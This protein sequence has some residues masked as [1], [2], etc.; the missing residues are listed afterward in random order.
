MSPIT[1]TKTDADGTHYGSPFIGPVN[2]TVQ[3]RINPSTLTTAEVDADGRLKPGVP[4]AADGTL[5]G[6]AEAVYGV[7]YEF[8]KVAAGNTAPDLAAATAA[9]VA[10]ATIAQVNRDQVEAN[11]G[12]ALTAAELAGFALAGSHLVLVQ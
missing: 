7:S 3:L 2:H 12:R 5:V 8:P 4:F 10:V 11:L 9:D 6:A 1:W